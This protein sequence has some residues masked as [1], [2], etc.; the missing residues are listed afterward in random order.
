MPCSTERGSDGMSATSS[1][2]TV[3]PCTAWRAW[4][5]PSETAGANGTMTVW[6]AVKATGA[7]ALTPKSAAST[8]AKPSAGV[9][10]AAV[11][12]VPQVCKVYAARPEPAALADVVQNVAEFASCD[13]VGNCRP[14]VVY[15]LPA[16]VTPCTPWIPFSEPALSSLMIAMLVFAA[17][18]VVEVFAVQAMAVNFGVTVDE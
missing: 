11:V 2:P 13:T 1:E 7:V 16:K 10:L 6:V 12:A 15:G 18:P 17:R 4:Y 5:R 14:P 3:L 9:T 8:S